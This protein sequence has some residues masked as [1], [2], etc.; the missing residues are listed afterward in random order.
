MR[1]Y[2]EFIV[3][4]E[5]QPMPPVEELCPSLWAA[6]DF[7]ADGDYYAEGIDGRWTDLEV[8]RREP[9]RPRTVLGVHTHRERGPYTSG[10][11]DTVDLQRYIDYRNDGRYDHD[12]EGV[13]DIQTAAVTMLCLD[14]SSVEDYREFLETVRHF[15]E[16]TGGTLVNCGQLLDAAGFAEHYLTPESDDEPAAPEV[17]P[18]GR[19]DGTLT[20]CSAIALRLEAARRR[21]C[22]VV[23]LDPETAFLN[24]LRRDGRSRV[25]MGGLSPLNDAVASRLASDKFHTAT[26]L[27]SVGLRVPDG[28]R[29]LRPGRFA[30]FDSHTG[31][32]PALRLAEQRGFPLVV[33]PNGGSRGRGIELVRDR[34]ELLRAIE[35]TW[36]DDY[37]ALVQVPAPGT[38]L[39]VDLLDG[40]CIFAY[41]RGPLMLRADGERSLAQLLAD[42][43]PRLTAQWCTQHLAGDPRWQRLVEGQ[44]L[45]LRS[46][47]EAGRSFDF[48][49][50][51]LNLN[52]LSVCEVVDPLPPEWTAL[53]RRVAERMG[54]RHLGV[55]LKI[56]ALDQDPA[57]AV[58][59]E[60]NASPSLSN[61]ALAGHYERVISVE[62][63]IV[64]AILAGCG[65]TTVGS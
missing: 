5:D 33:K 59:I 47:P 3:L 38:D 34:M 37:L 18:P 14:S 32:G 23:C 4:Y 57:D 25:L 24:E 1:F 52:R 54:L 13:R 61:M 17:R 8:R 49:G 36:I 19:S 53:A 46:I 10:L 60:V 56:D 2:S 27:S 26:A 58:I 39:R 41:R 44:G 15:L 35:A 7:D 43:D 63:R 55:D 42:A 22:E 11:T 48:G 45:S 50:V 51:I 29:C 16:Q 30:G 20:R 31:H 64:E 6:A 28:V 65:G 9:G 21:R 40:D 62:E 12:D